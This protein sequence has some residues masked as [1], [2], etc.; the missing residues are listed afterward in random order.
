MPFSRDLEK[1][2]A[3]SELEA[4][5]VIVAIDANAKLKGEIIYNKNQV[6]PGIRPSHYI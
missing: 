5:S 3:L 1:E 6:R 2:I 4:K